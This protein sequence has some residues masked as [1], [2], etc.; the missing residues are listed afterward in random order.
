MNGCKWRFAK[1]DGVCKDIV[2]A[3]SGDRGKCPLCGAEMVAKVGEVKVPH[4]SHFGKRVC[5]DWYQP[6]GPW[7]IA[8]QNQFDPSWQECPK[9]KHDMRHIADVYTPSG[10]TVEF[11]MSKILEPERRARESFYGDMIWVVAA[12]KEGS[13]GFTAESIKYW[14]K[15]M[16]TVDGAVYRLF[17]DNYRVFPRAWRSR[18]KLVFFDT[19]PQCVDDIPSKRLVCF[20]PT[21]PIGGSLICCVIK[22]S[23][24]INTLKNGDIGKS[25]DK[26]LALKGVHQRHLN[27]S[28][29]KR[30]FCQWD[31]S[32]PVRYYPP[33]ECDP[34]YKRILE[35]EENCPKPIPV[36]A[37]LDQMRAWQ[38]AALR[39]RRPR[40]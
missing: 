2:D 1:V 31:P 3:A 8:W 21:D 30:L 33:G 35:E 4:W 19:D 5:D 13:F 20:V 36:D 32:R 38:C 29:R 17:D 34:E 10:W 18:K 25:L 28:K 16:K 37:T 11:Q 26:L 9:V 24:L 39:C 14:T 6:K 22:A 12:E 15:G 23:E 40:F 27:L 7:H